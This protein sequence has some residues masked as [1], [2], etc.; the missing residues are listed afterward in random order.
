MWFIIRAAFCVGIVFSMTPS[1]E[2]IDDTGNAAAALVAVATPAMHDLADGVLSACKSEAKLCLEAAQR[3]A[4]AGSDV[5]AP[6]PKAGAPDG[7]R[8]AA[9]TLTATDRA[10]PWHGTS[11]RA[12]ARPKEASRPA[13]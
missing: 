3:F 11:R 8:V 12:S 13:S 4:G 2:V 5:L 7:L 6:A 1:G 10:V 9:D